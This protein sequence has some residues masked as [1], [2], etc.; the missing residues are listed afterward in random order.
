MRVRLK[1]DSVSTVQLRVA[2]LQLK[3]EGCEGPRVKVEGPEKWGFETDPI[4]TKSA[5]KVL[6]ALN[7]V[8]VE[9]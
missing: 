1:A 6:A 5:E 2:A 9:V 3:R 4:S 8:E 7:D